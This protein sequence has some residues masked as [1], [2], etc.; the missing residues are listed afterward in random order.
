MS[1]DAFLFLTSAEGL[2]NLRDIDGDAYFD[3]LSSFDDFKSLKTVSGKVALGMESVSDLL[4]AD[5]KEVVGDNRNLG[6]R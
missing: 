4:D 2:D 1:I 5:R 6:L 3:C